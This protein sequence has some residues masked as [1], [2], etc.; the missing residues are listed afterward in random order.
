MSDCTA[1]RAAVPQLQAEERGSP[2]MEANDVQIPEHGQSLPFLNKLNLHHASD[3]NA[4]T[5]I[6]GMSHAWIHL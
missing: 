2:A 4:A 3:Y 6:H 1:F 5:N